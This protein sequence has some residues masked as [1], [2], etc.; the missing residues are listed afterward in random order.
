MK[1]LLGFLILVQL[2]YNNAYSQQG[3]HLIESLGDSNNSTSTNLMTDRIKEAANKYQQYAPIPRLAELDYAFASDFVEYE[4]LNGFGILYITSLNQDSDEYPIERVYFKYKDGVI[5]LK[6][7]GSINIPV[8]D[9][10]IKKVFGKNRIDYYYYLPYMI[11]RL[12]GQLLVDWKKNRKEFLLLHFPAENKLDYITDN[13]KIL[14]DSNKSI[15]M[16]SLDKFA[17]R[18]FK[19]KLKPLLRAR[20]N[21]FGA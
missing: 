19:I 16:T 21:W 5:D 18:E 11:T 20:Y 15:D 10:L 13:K 8:T 2:S 17:Q 4:K 12:S 1:R 14:P 6:L 3:L 9:N 7:I